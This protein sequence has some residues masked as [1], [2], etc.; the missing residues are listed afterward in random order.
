VLRE[1]LGVRLEGPE[2]GVPSAEAAGRLLCQSGMDLAPLLDRRHFFSAANADRCYILSRG[3]SGYLIHRLGWSRYA[4]II[5]TRASG[6]FAAA[7][8]G[9]S[10]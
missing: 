4:I 2:H 8:S 6:T 9:S 10:A 1:R 3:V 5:A 7:S